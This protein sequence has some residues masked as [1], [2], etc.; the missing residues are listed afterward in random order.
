MNTHTFQ[1]ESREYFILPFILFKRFNRFTLHYIQCIP[2]QPVHSSLAKIY[3]AFMFALRT[4]CFSLYR[5]SLLSNSIK[6]FRCVPCM[7]YGIFYAHGTHM[8][9][10]DLLNNNSSF[11]LFHLNVN[12]S[13]YVGCWMF[14]RKIKYFLYD[15]IFFECGRRPN[16]LFKKKKNETIQIQKSKIFQWRAVWVSI[17]LK[18]WSLIRMNKNR[19]VFA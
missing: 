17:R 9:Q 13:V 3:F 16:I 10:Q 11:S 19:P 5:K 15:R 6:L 8:T 18:M 7:Q 2:A 4:F 12:C 1:T 14:V